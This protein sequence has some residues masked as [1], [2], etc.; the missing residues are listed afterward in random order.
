[1]LS[2]LVETHSG[3]K[4]VSVMKKA[5]EISRCSLI[6]SLEGLSCLDTDT[7]WIGFIKSKSQVLQEPLTSFQMYLPIFVVCNFINR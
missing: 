6:I 1:M 5:L 7:P 2:W 3:E 4:F